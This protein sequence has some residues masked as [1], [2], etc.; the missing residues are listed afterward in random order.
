MKKI[1]LFTYILLVSLTSASLAGEDSSLFSKGRKFA[2]SNQSEFA[3]M[4][5]RD[6]IN[7]FPNSPHREPALF[8]SGEYYAAIPDH[9]E[10]KRIFDQF[11]TEY[12]DSKSKIFVLAYLY[13]IAEFNDDTEQMEKLKR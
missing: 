12:P 2:R 7:N 10:S 5:F 9:L 6:I 11:L 8:A 13:K 3:Y 1:L 4:Q